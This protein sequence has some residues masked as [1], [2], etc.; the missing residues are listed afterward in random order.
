M[1]RARYTQP[2][3]SKWVGIASDGTEIA[4]SYQSALI[5]EAFINKVMA[6]LGQHPDP[7]V[8]LVVMSAIGLDQSDRVGDAPYLHE[9][10]DGAD[11]VVRESQNK[12]STLI[13]MC[14]HKPNGAV[15][16]FKPGNSAMVTDTRYTVSEETF[17]SQVEK[18]A[19]L[20]SVPYPI[21]ASYGHLAYT[22]H[23][24]VR[25]GEKRVRD[26]SNHV[27]AVPQI[28]VYAHRESMGCTVVSDMGASVNDIWELDMPGRY[29]LK[30]EFFPVRTTADVI[31]GLA[32]LN[33]PDLLGD[34]S[35]KS[36]QAMVDAMWMRSGEKIDDNLTD[37]GKALVTDQ[38]REVGMTQYS[39]MEIRNGKTSG[40]THAG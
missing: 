18:Y 14:E 25:V 7:D 29:L 13:A 11:W 26:K 2:I 28:L 20:L 3:P 22:I 23:P 8:R 24:K 9:S 40:W 35:Y 30:D 31:N 36:L 38:C 17:R 37:S 15:C 12:K 21:D 32:S 10:G 6:H 39:D 16:H 27:M 4:L 1:S 34:P 5:K 33:D 19:E